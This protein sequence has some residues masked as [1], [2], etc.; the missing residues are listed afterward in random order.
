M[1]RTSQLYNN[2]K[3]VGAEGHEGAPISIQSYVEGGYCEVG[4]GEVPARGDAGRRIEDVEK[5][6]GVCEGFCD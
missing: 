1:E 4:R 3:V 6:V 2:W 5:E